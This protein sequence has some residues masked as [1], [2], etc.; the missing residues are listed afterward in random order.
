[1]IRV[2]M[3]VNHEAE[4][5]GLDVHFGESGQDQVINVFRTSSIQKQNALFSAQN[6]KVDRTHANLSFQKK[7]IIV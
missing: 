1:M 5:L 4:I 2:G 6:R 3:S 7:D